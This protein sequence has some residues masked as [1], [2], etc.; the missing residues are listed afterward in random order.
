MNQTKLTDAYRAFKK[1]GR[2]LTQTDDP[3]LLAGGYL[4]WA[5]GDLQRAIRTLETHDGRFL[6]RPNFA[7]RV[8]AL[9]LLTQCREGP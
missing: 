9:N 1:S 6:D 5:G 2:R 8:E 3:K 7:G 4:D